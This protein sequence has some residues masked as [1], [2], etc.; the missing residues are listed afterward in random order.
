M[1]SGG[2][3]HRASLHSPWA[4]LTGG[5]GSGHAASIPGSGIQTRAGPF[6]SKVV[7]DWSANESIRKLLAAEVLS[8]RRVC[9]VLESHPKA[10]CV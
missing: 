2:P 10:I 3:R 5:L 1:I 8:Q 7:V 6:V 9:T 4:Q